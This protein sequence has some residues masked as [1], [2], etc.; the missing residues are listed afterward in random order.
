MRNLTRRSMMKAGGGLLATTALGGLWRP[1]RAEA[2]PIT[3]TALGGKPARMKDNREIP[4]TLEALWQYP[5]GTLV[6]FS[7]FNA[8]GGAWSLPG[9][10]LEVR[11]TKGTLYL[12]GDGYEV[13][14]E[15]I[16][17][18]SAMARGRLPW[19]SAIRAATACTIVTGG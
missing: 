15:A 17:V 10:E 6:T 4:D 13:M 9:C 8:N 19:C 18:S 11:G 2:A 5:G 7:Q 16:S 12:F 3:V 14:P 1:A